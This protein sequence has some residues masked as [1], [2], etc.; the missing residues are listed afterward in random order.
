M[1]SIVIPTYNGGKYI[2]QTIKSALNQ[3]LT[4]VE[5]LVIDDGSDENL[6]ELLAPYSGSIQYIYKERSGPAASRN[7]GIKLSRGTY[8]AFLDHDDL[9]H[10]D[11]LRIQAGIMDDNPQCALVYCYPTLIDAEGKTIHNEGPSHFPS[12]NVA[13]DFFK[14][15]RITTFSSALIRKSVFDITGLLDESPEVMTCDDYDMWLRISDVSEVIFA[16]GDLVHY[17][18]H[19]GNLVKNY[20][21]NLRAHIFVLEKFFRSSVRLKQLPAPLVRKT[22]RENKYK[23]YCYFAFIYYYAQGG[24]RKARK[25]FLEALRLQPYALSLMPYLLICH[26]PMGFRTFA[27]KIKSLFSPQSLVKNTAVE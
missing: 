12:G 10:P 24:E 7:L 5:I 2:C 20:D 8:I 15:N 4:D 6:S 17:R 21:Q 25:L 11:K 18:I 23:K 13:L 14:G 27:R 16:P 1:I 26:M 22:L 3:T 9:W 19:S